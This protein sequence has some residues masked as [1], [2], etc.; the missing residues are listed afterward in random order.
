MGG[1]P[2]LDPDVRAAL[3][4]FQQETGIQRIIVFGSR[5]RGDAAPGS[6][7]DIL[8]IDPRFEGQAFFKRSVGLRRKLDLQMGVDILCYTPEEFEGLRG[9]R[10]LV[11]HAADEGVVV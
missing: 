4:R 5:A 8:L 7:L 10:T 2:A 6:D 3:E 11:H 1:A 9:Q